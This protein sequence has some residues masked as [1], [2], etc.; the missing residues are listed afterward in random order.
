MSDA[1][2]ETIEK[3]RAEIGDH[4]RAL[5]ANDEWAEVEKL[6][7]ALGVIEG[8][9]GSSRTSLADLFGFSDESAGGA[10]VR[11][12]EFMGRDAVD[13]AKL[14]LE[15]KK[16]AA[17]SL[18]EIMGAVEKGGAS[19]ISRDALRVSLVR[20]TWDVF[21]APGQDLYTL[22]KFLPHVRRGKK[23]SGA[24]RPSTND[25]ESAAVGSSDAETEPATEEV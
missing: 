19:Q 10:Y 4:V 24:E 9:A 8:L 23:K 3:L 17:S 1:F 22:V 25:Q 15:K 13:A 11:A 20:S 2:D 6:Y 18:D 12:G 21:K 5:K 7:R 14:Y 16:D